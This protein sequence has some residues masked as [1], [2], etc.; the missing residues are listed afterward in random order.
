MSSI[1]GD[2]LAEILRQIWIFSWSIILKMEATTRDDRQCQQVINW[3]LDLTTKANWRCFDIIK[4]VFSLEIQR[5]HW[6]HKKLDFNMERQIG[7]FDGIWK[8]NHTFR[9]RSNCNPN[10]TKLNSAKDTRLGVH[11]NEIPEAWE[12]GG[13]FFKNA[14]FIAL[15]GVSRQFRPTNSNLTLTVWRWVF[16][17][18]SKGPICVLSSRFPRWISHFSFKLKMK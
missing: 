1:D 13:L 14:I 18:T 2:S 6:I 12:G 10:W 3:D 4:R 7:D 5:T 15:S 11:L 8:K 17:T 16:G 9:R